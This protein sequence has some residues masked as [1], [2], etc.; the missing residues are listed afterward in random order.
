MQVASGSEVSILQIAAAKQHEKWI[1]SFGEKRQ[2]KRQCDLYALMYVEASRENTIK[3]VEDQ[4]KSISWDLLRRGI[5]SL[6]SVPEAYLTI[7]SHFARTLASFSIGSYLIGIGDRHLENFLLSFKDGGL[8]GIDFG[9]AFGSATQFL[10]IPELVPFRLTRQFTNFL[11]PLDSEG[12]LFHNMRHTLRALRNHKDVLLSTMDVFV[13][14]PLIDWEKLARRLAHEQR[15]G[16]DEDGDSASAWFVKE[17]IAVAKMKLEGHHP[18]H[19]IVRELSSSVHASR[20]F[21]PSLSNIVLG[22]PKYDT[23][24]SL[25]SQGLSVDDQV[26]ALV[27]LSSDPAVLGRMYGGW[28]PWI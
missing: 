12:L 26:E 2:I 19:I 22:D 23:R 15:S 28:A 8:V 24:A 17:K 4:W 11:L 21:I 13:T 6:C 14:E 16:H 25:P 27:D 7:R 18:S 1:A 20:P 9:H 10:P 3:K 5:M